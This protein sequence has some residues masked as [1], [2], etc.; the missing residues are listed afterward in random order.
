MKI[1]EVKYL[2]DFVLECRF[3]HGKM[4]P[5]ILAVF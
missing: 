4:L 1:V 3:K 5:P 2:G